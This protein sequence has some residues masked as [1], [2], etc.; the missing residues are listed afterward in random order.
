VSIIG[1]QKE[2]VLIVETN[3]LT[4]SNSLQVTFGKEHWQLLK[5]H[6]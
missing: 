1:G 6:R 3:I 4:E 5:K 2:S